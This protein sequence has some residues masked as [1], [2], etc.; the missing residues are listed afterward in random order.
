MGRPVSRPRGDVDVL[1]F[2]ARR[3]DAAEDQKYE[4]A[5]RTLE[6]DACWSVK[7]QARMHGRN[8]DAPYASVTDATRHWPET[9]TAVAARRTMSE[10]CEIVAPFGL[11][12]LF[13]LK[14][15]PTPAFATNK[16]A[17]FDDRIKQKGWL[18]AWP[19]LRVVSAQANLPENRD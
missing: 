15:S 7:N 19:R 16:R 9:V 11:E 17:L 13:G 2:D 14:L 6:P 5:L 18:T 8:G 12:D 4:A 3:I 10:E 1:W